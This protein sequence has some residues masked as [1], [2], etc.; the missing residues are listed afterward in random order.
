MQGS[1]LRREPLYRGEAYT[2]QRYRVSKSKRASW[3]DYPVRIKGVGNSRCCG[4]PTLLVRT[5]EGGFVKELCSTCRKTDNLSNPEF[6]TISHRLHV[7]CPECGG[8]MSVDNEAREHGN[9]AFLCEPCDLLLRLGDLV[10]YR[11]DDRMELG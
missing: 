1:G 3:E 10:P 8:E 9:Y 11:R 4:S 2:M 6:L 5:S 7:E